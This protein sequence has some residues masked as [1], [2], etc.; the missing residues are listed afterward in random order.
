VIIS[1]PQDGTTRATLLIVGS[2]VVLFLVYLCLRDG[3][4][5]NRGWKVERATRP[6]LY[7]FLITLFVLLS[8]VLFWGGVSLGTSKAHEALGSLRRAA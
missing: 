3:V 2:A 8:G 5:P 7:W 4:V 1:F 6:L